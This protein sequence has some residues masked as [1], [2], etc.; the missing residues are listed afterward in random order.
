MTTRTEYGVRY[1][2]Y[3][4]GQGK[5][6]TVVE[7]L[8]AINR[9]EAEQ[10]EAATREWQAATEGELPVD[11]EIVTRTITTTEWKNTK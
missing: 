1:T 9:D 7:P 2:G 5:T 6:K 11:A 3:R 10:A 4:H 8:D